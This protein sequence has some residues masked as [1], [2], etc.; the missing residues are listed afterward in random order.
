MRKNERETER[1]E[2]DWRVMERGNE[3]EVKMRKTERMACSIIKKK[4]L[5]YVIS[6]E[7]A[8]VRKSEF[9]TATVPLRFPVSEED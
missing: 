2:R 9:K 6:H 7:E 3:R 4:A 8:Q 5:A 1:D